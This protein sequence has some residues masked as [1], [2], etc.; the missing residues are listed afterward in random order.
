VAC[1][2]VGRVGEASLTAFIKQLTE[3]KLDFGMNNDDVCIVEAKK[4]LEENRLRKINL[5]DEHK[6]LALMKSISEF[7]FIS[8]ISRI[9]Q[10]NG[11]RNFLDIVTYNDYFENITG[12][13]PQTSTDIEK[14]IDD[15][16]LELRMS[17]NSPLIIEAKR[18]LRRFN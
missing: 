13:G 11:F 6:I 1:A 7:G 10:T 17:T 15:E 12:I 3:Y 5:S 16:G 14:H 2:R 8:R 9:L 4:L 18:R